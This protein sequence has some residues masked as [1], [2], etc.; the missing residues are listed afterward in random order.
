M[1]EKGRKL[2]NWKFVLLFA[3]I[4]GVIYYYYLQALLTLVVTVTNISLLQIVPNDF[5]IEGILDGLDN[6]NFLRVTTIRVVLASVPVYLI[7]I[8]CAV[9]SAWVLLCLFIVDIPRIVLAFLTY[10]Q[11]T[12]LEDLGYLEA[13]A[14]SGVNV[15]GAFDL[16]FYLGFALAGGFILCLFCFFFN[17]LFGW[18]F[19]CAEKVLCCCCEGDEEK[20]LAVV[21][22]AVGGGGGSGGSGGVCCVCKGVFKSLKCLLK[23]AEEE[24]DE[25]SLFCCIYD[26]VCSE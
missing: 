9:R 5:D 7:F 10:T 16:A 8:C 11:L 22:E 1:T 18:C 2:N 24:S 20:G 6:L 23:C 19:G 26:L 12:E 13:S 3:L 17:Y 25:G 14:A 15:E 4:W 21:G